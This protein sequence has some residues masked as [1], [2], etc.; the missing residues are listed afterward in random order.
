MM[1]S[2]LLTVNKN[3]QSSINLE[4]DLGKESKIE[5][6]I[7]TTDIC[8]VIKKYVK[9]FLGY[10]NDNATT[11]IGPY[12]KGKSFLLL[13]L[14]YLIGK[15][16]CTAAWMKLV[17]KIGKIDPELY[18]LLLEI[19]EKNICLLPILI[20]SNY[21]NLTQSFRLALNDALKRE[22]LNDIIPDSAFDVCLDLIKK[23]SSKEETKDEIYEKCLQK[24]KINI[25]ELKKGLAS[26]SPIAYKQFEN[27]YNCVN[28]GLAFNPLVNNDIV[29]TYSDT[30]LAVS[31]K[32]YSGIFI[33][34]DE[35]SKF[36]ES[37]SSNLMK[38]LKILQDFAE[39]SSRSGKKTQIHL[40]CV[41]HKS[42]SL[43]KEAKNQTNLVDSFKT[44]EG[45]FKEIR[46]NRSLNENYQIISAAIIKK[47]GAEELIKKRLKENAKFYDDVSAL[48]IFNNKDFQDVLYRNCFPLN[49]ITVYSLIEI[50]ELAAQNE[51]T[52]FTFL[53]DTDDDSFNSFIHSHS[54]GL[55]DIDKIYDYFNL[56]LKSS[57]DER[58]RNLWYR[59]E[60]I[61]SKL[62]S[63]NEKRI[64]KALS[65][66][67]VIDNQDLLPAN[68]KTISLSLEI[69]ESSCA[70]SIISLIDKHLLRKNALDNNFS[71]ALSNSKQ[72]DDALALLRKTKCKNI[73][74]NEVADQINEKKYILPREYNEKN[75]ITRFFKT[76][77]LSELDFLNIPS[78]NYYF[79]ENYC[80]GVIVYLLSNS[81]SQNKIKN[82]LISLNDKRVVVKFSQKVIPSALG[83]LLTTYACLNELKKQK[84]LDEVTQ[85]QIDLITDETISDVHSILND[86]FESNF[87]FASVLL[88]SGD[89]FNRLLSKVM[90]N[91]YSTRLVFNNELINKKN[92]T[93][94][95]QK[96]INHVI[97]W[98]LNGS[99]D[100]DYSETS[101]EM[102]VK[103]AILD[104]NSKT[105][106][107][108]SNNFRDVID[109]LK[110][111]I[112]DTEGQRVAVRSIVEFLSKPPY[113]I[114]IGVLP[115]L[116]AKAISE[117][118]DNAILY[119]QRKE[120]ELNANNLVKAISNEKYQISFA[121]GA[122]NQDDYL[123]KMIRLFN[124]A[125]SNNFR[126]DTFALSKAINRFFMR[127]P[128]VI[129]ICSQKN[130]FLRLNDS[131]IA[132]KDLFLSFDINP[133]EAVFQKP[134]EIFQTGTYE[135]TFLKIRELVTNADDLLCQFYALIKGVIRKT[136]NIDENTSLKS[137]FN[138]FLKSKLKNKGKPILE[139]KSKQ[140]YEFL[141]DELTYSDDE[142]ASRLVKI[143]TGQAIE[144]WDSNKIES[145]KNA[146]NDFKTSISSSV[147]SIDESS[148]LDELLNKK[149]ELSGV[150]S[151]LK[152]NLE[153]VLE[154]FSGSVTSSD[155]VNVLL[156][157]LKEIL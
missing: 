40:C 121:R 114:R 131:F 47:D 53:S 50:S 29:K 93:T 102:S 42:L 16:K 59:T 84:N 22:N 25:K 86:C 149:Y 62:E 88:E 83:D 57:D 49:P 103:I 67:L 56:L 147:M 130:N 141:C 113:G 13:V 152:N 24:N 137:G 140:I 148:N 92:I 71:F 17:N 154:E 96:A 156:S 43:Y 33:I 20:N 143:I 142:C 120:I 128:Q 155:K 11:L 115:V 138:D 44:V 85:A 52:L 151:L 133:Y 1:Y 80:D 31:K 78:F 51:R 97:D 48:P 124:V 135:N 109:R 146:L 127:M 37:N 123:N 3:F 23:W 46:F 38:D 7:P 153:S 64:V 19:K 18:N 79:E 58:I 60:S 66:I 144:D 81:V 15:N 27:L 36:L 157:L 21:D 5:E 117:L 105:K 10:T 12:G 55:F 32:G 77:F 136:F 68:L 39:L 129:R 90:T 28:I 95:Y 2:D 45:R 74:L 30:V 14:S 91:I 70:V 26:Y 107:I 116:F 94:Q 100:F 9:S 134:L 108:S 89:T 6:Y 75:K 145:F 119:F 104:E 112:I 122:A 111:K 101:P 126:K 99:G 82:K 35:F 72:I 76:L 61:L 106:D 65:I 41:A 54:K 98:L 63:P 73:R 132:F 118:S 69:D 139:E 150:S 125:S 4:L 110:E 87:G 8:D 34:F